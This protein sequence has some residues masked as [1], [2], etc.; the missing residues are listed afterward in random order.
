MI[1]I[2]NDN[3]FSYVS[4]SYPTHYLMIKM[5]GQF[6][7]KISLHNFSTPNMKGCQS[8]SLDNYFSII[9]LSSLE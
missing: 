7:N 5:T 3:F 8:C 9:S 2:T 1:L 6:D 4:L